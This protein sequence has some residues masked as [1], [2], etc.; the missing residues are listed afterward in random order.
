MTRAKR[1]TEGNVVAVPLEDGGFGFGVVVEEPL[2]AFFTRRANTKEMPA[3]ISSA[4]IAFS[5]WVMNNAIGKAHWSIVGTIDLP[6][7]VEL[8][9]WFFKKDIISGKY[10]L[11]RHLEEK[12]ALR[13]DCVNLERAAVWEPEHVESRLTDFLAGREHQNKWVR[14]LA[15]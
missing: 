11:Y 2:V 13:D 15:L 14:S 5:V 7:H 9:P 8:D 10:S 6:S 12:P 4:A 3:D 1:W